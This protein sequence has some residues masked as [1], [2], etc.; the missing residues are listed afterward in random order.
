MAYTAWSVVDGETSTDAKL[1][2]LR[3]NDAGFVDGTN[4]SNDILTSRHF[5]DI[6]V[7]KRL[8][9]IE[10]LGGERQLDVDLHHAAKYLKVLVNMSCTGG[11]WASAFIFNNDQAVNYAY[12]IESD[13]GQPPTNLVSR[14][15]FGFGIQ[16][17]PGERDA[18]IDI[19]NLQNQYKIFQVEGQYNFE[20]SGSSTQV[21]DNR[22]VGKW[23]NNTSVISR[24]SM[25]TRGSSPSPG[26][27]DAGTGFVVFGRD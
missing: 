8:G 14:P 22:L 24:I 27:F 7:W 3:D 25:F 23:A 13:F 18:I 19:V 10:A 1:N 16:T 6:A 2:Q 4:L 9:D 26:T 15:N 12:W 11:D 5:Q 21:H 20:L 17:Q